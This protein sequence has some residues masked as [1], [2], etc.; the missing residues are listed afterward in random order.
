MNRT[1]AFLRYVRRN[2]TL[3]V[4]LVIMILLTLFC[5]IG[6]RLT[7]VKTQ[8]YPL[9]GPVNKPPSALFW[10]G[11][12]AQGRNL[13]ATIVVGTVLTLRIGLT[14]GAIGLGVGTVLAFIAAYYRGWFDTVIR[15]V[16][17]V[18]LTI[19]GLLVLVVIASVNR[20]A[21]TVESMA[22][23]VASLAWLGPTRNIRAQVLSLRERPFV[24]VAR[25]SGMNGL[26]IIFRELMPNL[27]P[28]LAAAFVGSVTGAIFASIGL[29]ALGLGPLREP[30]LGMTIYWVLYYSALLKGLWWWVIAPIAVVVLIFV[31]LFL[32]GTGLDEL[33]NPRVRRMA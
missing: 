16:V 26:E 19:P 18:L 31:S 11:T 32:L 5:V 8:P 12:D 27:L 17:D 28:Y 7:D 15:G 33:A 6:W 10:F 2:P 20:R 24:L 21:M 25:L 4:G 3:A 14:A 9:A 1:T 23:V 22:L 30:T 29:E 13:F